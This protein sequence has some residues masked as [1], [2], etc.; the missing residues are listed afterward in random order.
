[1]SAK[2]AW[3]KELP[4]SISGESY[5]LRHVDDNLIAFSNERA[6]MTNT[7]GQVSFEVPLIGQGKSVMEFFRNHNGEL[8]SCFVRGDRVLVMKGS[9]VK[10]QF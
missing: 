9:K 5:M 7:Q 1:M 3:R 10:G 6:I 4:S 8:V 2:P